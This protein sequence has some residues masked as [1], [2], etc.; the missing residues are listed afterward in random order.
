MLYPDYRARLADTKVKV[1]EYLDSAE[2]QDSKNIDF[3][4]PV[5]LAIR[6]TTGGKGLVCKND[7]RNGD[8]RTRS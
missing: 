3:N 1:G 4:G 6:A 2:A 8:R 5:K 7:H